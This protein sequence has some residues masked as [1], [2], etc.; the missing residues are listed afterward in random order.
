GRRTKRTTRQARNSLLLQKDYDELRWLRHLCC[1]TDRV[2]VVGSFIESLPWNESDL[3]AAPGWSW[4]KRV[5]GLLCIAALQ[6]HRRVLVGFATC[7]ER[8]LMPPLAQDEGALTLSRSLSKRIGSR[9][10]RA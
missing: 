4:R 7:S 5:H 10:R 3:L 6:R 9:V 1:E 8:R 2:H